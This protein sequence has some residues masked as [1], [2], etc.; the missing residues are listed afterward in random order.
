MMDLFHSR[1][2]A[3]LNS[4]M[5]PNDVELTILMRMRLSAIVGGGLLLGYLPSFSLS[6][7]TLMN[8][9]QLMTLLR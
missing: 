1:K 8:E 9:C 7:Q 6:G 2:D 5:L 3:C 4:G